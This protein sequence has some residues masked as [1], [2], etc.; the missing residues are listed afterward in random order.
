MVYLFE[1]LPVIGW[2]NHILKLPLLGEDDKLDHPR[3]LLVRPGHQVAPVC[4][5]VMDLEV[6]FLELLPDV[7]LIKLQEVLVE[8]TKIPGILPRQ[9]P[10]ESYLTN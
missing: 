3:H 1:K 2:L 10:S 5:V 8:H 7:T 4:R 6:G 9:V